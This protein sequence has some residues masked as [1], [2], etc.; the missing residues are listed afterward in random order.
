M[1]L[2]LPARQAYVPSGAILPGVAL[3]GQVFLHTPTGRNILYEYDGTDWRPIEAYG[4]IDVYVDNTDGTDDLNYGFGVDGDAFQTI[5]YAHDII[6]P[7][8]LDSA[9]IHVNDEVYAENVIIGGHNMGRGMSTANI[10]LEGT[11]TLIAGGNTATGGVQGAAAVL[12]SVTDVGLVPNAWDKMLIKFTSGAN[13]GLWR[14]IDS[15]N[16]GNIFLAG[17]ALNAAP[18]AGDTYDIY[19]WGTTITG[20]VGISDGNKAWYLINDIK[21]TGFSAQNYGLVAVESTVKCT[22]VNV[23]QNQNGFVAATHTYM[24]LHQCLHVSNAAGFRYAVLAVGLSMV[25]PIKGS[26]FS[27]NGGNSA[28][29]VACK[30]DYIGIEG[31]T[32]IDGFGTDVQAQGDSYIRFHLDTSTCRTHVIN[33]TVWGVRA[34]QG[35]T[36]TGTANTVYAG[37]ALDESADAASFS[38]VD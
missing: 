5:Q 11:L 18:G 15:N 31:G 30:N 29:C 37:N 10:T 1:S 9:V 32:I 34:G 6:P 27:G 3:V 26:I 36:V 25:A 19:D 13:N 17:D 4:T 38:Y 7:D 22:R 16:A 8:I 35:S 28:G 24:E 12:P 33:A 23:E 2:L 20:Y 14:V 21:I